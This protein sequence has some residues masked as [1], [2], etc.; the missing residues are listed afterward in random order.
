MC[1]ERDEQGE[2]KKERDCT[3]FSKKREKPMIR[4]LLNKRD[5]A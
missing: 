2:R 5:A 3:Q 4:L 1:D